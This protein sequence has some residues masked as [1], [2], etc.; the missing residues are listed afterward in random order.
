MGVP[1]LRANFRP[2]SLMFR[3]WAT[4]VPPPCHCPLEAVMIQQDSLGSKA[5]GVTETQTLTT[6]DRI[7]LQG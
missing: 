2:Q 7:V 3:P 4:F 6:V 1:S 5:V